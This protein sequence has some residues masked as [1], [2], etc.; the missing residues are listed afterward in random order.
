METE[1]VIR[2]SIPARKQRLTGTVILDNGRLTAPRFIWTD[3]N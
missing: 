3:R 2:A 1:L